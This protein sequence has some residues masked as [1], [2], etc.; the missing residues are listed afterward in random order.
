MSLLDEKSITKQD[1]IY[2]AF[3]VRQPL[4]F[5]FMKQ[6]LAYVAQK[7]AGPYIIGTLAKASHVNIQKPPEEDFAIESLESWPHVPVIINTSSDSSGQSIL[8]GYVQSIFPSPISQLR[9]LTEAIVEQKLRSMG[10]DLAIN[11]ISDESDFWKYVKENKGEITSLSFDFAAPNFFNTKDKLNDELREAKKQYDITHAQIKL[12]NEFGALKIPEK[13]KFIEEGLKYVA[14]GGGE[15]KLVLK[16]KQTISNKD[17]T[18]SV[19]LNEKELEIAFQKRSE[20]EAFCDKLFL[21]LDS[22][23]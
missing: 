2:E 7:E 12:D 14:G 13:N 9:A 8:I 16:T 20:L 21:W 3:N 15:Y 11:A 1:L 19:T 17:A 6:R 22:S 4:Y 18:K 23:G 10:Y 5:N